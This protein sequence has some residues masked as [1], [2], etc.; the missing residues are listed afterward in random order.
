MSVNHNSN[1]QKQLK[2]HAKCEL[3]FWLTFFSVLSFSFILSACQTTAPTL[4]AGDDS[5]GFG[6]TGKQQEHTSGFGG[7][8]KSSPGFGGTG[9]VGTI[10]QF[11]SIWVNGIEIGYGSKTEISSEL[12][13]SD[14]LKKGKQVVLETLPLKDKTITKSIRIFYP[15][16][17]EIT[18]K[19]PDMLVIN[20][21]YKVALQPDT[22]KDQN[23]NE[24]LGSFVA[25]SGYQVA[26]NDWVATRLNLN[27]DKRVFYHDMP[28][29]NFSNQVNKVVIEAGL[30]QLDNLRWHDE[31]KSQFKGIHRLIIE[32]KGNNPERFRQEKIEPYQKFIRDQHQDQLNEIRH[33]NQS[34][35]QLREIEQMR[36]QQNSVVEKQHEQQELLNQQKQLLEMQSQHL[37]SMER[38]A[39]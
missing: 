19:T 4:L 25:I 5:S 24:E 12:S 39:D 7:T 18:D 29:L 27:P 2:P 36:S 13:T 17:G 1:G 9:I 31:I 26:E 30:M 16:A 38:N 14:S 11:G 33:E 28:T 37:E 22:L 34:S 32:A 6:G 8:G 20:H 21:Q 23:L 35:G 10:T 3:R 15:I